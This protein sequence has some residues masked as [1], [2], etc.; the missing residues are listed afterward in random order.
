MLSDFTSVHE[1]ASFFS[2]K[3]SELDEKH[4]KND[5]CE[6]SAAIERAY[7]HEVYEDCEEEDSTNVSIRPKIAQF[8]ANLDP[9]SIICDVGCGYGHYLTPNFNSS[10][11]SIGVERCCR[12]A[13]LAKASSLEVPYYYRI[14]MPQCTNFS[15][16]LFY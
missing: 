5:Y 16:F 9:G 1:P 8:I 12:I 3:I 14:S 7:V 10:I 2:Q 4:R 11:F 6:R 13:K 15:S